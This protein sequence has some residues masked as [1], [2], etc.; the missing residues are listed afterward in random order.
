MEITRLDMNETWTFIRTG[1]SY[2]FASSLF[3]V[4]TS[5]FHYPCFSVLCFFPQYYCL[6]VHVVT[7]ITSLHLSFGIP[8]LRCDHV[9]SLPSSMFSLLHLPLSFSPRGLTISVLRVSLVFAT[10]AV[11]RISSL[12]IFSILFIPFIHLN[13]L[14]SVLSIKSCSFLLSAKDSQ[15]SE[16]GRIMQRKKLSL[17]HRN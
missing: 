13:I 8:F 5:S 17:I 11:A 7:C 14:V 3:R 1:I 9:H 2:S 4:S 6:L 15:I 10:L 16:L 12:P